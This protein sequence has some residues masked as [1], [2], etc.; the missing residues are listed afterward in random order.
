MC[1][2][3][4]TKPCE[5]TRWPIRLHDCPDDIDH[6]FIMENS[7]PFY[8]SND[9]RSCPTLPHSDIPGLQNG[10]KSVITSFGVDNG[11]GNNIN[12]SGSSIHDPLEVQEDHHRAFVGQQAEEDCIYV[13]GG[14]FSG[15]WFSLGR[16]QSLDPNTLQDETFVCY[17]AGCLGVVAIMTTALS[18]QSSSLSPSSPDGR[19]GLSR[20]MQER[21]YKMARRIQ[22]DWDVGTLHRY[23][24]VEAFVDDLLLGHVDKEFPEVLYHNVK[25]LTTTVD[26][27]NHVW[28]ASISSPTNWMT[29]KTLLLQTTWIPF[30]IG[31]SF[32][33]R[34]HFDGAFSTIQHP[35]CTRTV[36]LLSVV[37]P[38]RVIADNWSSMSMITHFSKEWKL[39]TNTLNVNLS[40]DDVIQLWQMGLDLCV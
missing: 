38:K 12:S 29:L 26:P 18:D 16:L 7:V 28:K 17:S 8:A 14:G 21:M 10:T 3:T 4:H 9:I 2:L 34:D 37:P 39:W 36:G 35:N 11:S 33:Y 30:A 15:F 31:S 5:R 32:T 40:H 13:P 27:S 23:E 19:S 25:I 22:V 24:I 20:A 6:I 1:T